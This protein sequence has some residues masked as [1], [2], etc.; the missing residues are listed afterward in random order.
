MVLQVFLGYRIFNEK[1]VLRR[2]AACL[3]MVAGS[4]MVLQA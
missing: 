4:L 3:V 1:H 2:L